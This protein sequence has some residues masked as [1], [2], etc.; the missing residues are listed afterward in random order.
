[1]EPRPSKRKRVLFL[2]VAVTVA[3][4]ATLVMDDDSESSYRR[5]K[6][7]E[8]CSEAMG[9]TTEN[10]LFAL[11]ASRGDERRYG[12]ESQFWES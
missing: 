10:D 2:A 11:A 3:V 12:S 5:S 4:C 7:N 9:A 1:M 8:L 6:I